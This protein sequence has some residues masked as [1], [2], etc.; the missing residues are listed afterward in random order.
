MSGW[1]VVTLSAPL[2]SFGEEAGNVQRGS[3]QRP[4]RSALIGLAGA[5]FG[6][7]REDDEGQRA[8][9]EAF[10]VASRTISPGR[11]LVDFH[12]YQS[13]PRGQAVATRAEALNRRADLNTSITRR[14][15]RADGLW[16][17]A[18]AQRPAAR[19]TL[20]G[21]MAAF[22]QPLFALWLGRKSC[23]LAH[24]LCPV[25]VPTDD[26][27]VAFAT[28]GARVSL[29]AGQTGGTLGVDETDAHRPNA[30]RRERRVDEPLNRR[31]WHFGSRYELVYDMPESATPLREAEA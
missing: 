15:Y 14:T 21:L 8:L 7:S 20:D 22:R 30:Y 25:L 10:A 2:A 1:L 5:A 23:P 13:L 16:Q 11:P 19:F 31:R 4:T 26:V 6:I 27:T 12:T 17:A 18:Y 9:A 28:Q 24:P 3:S 29:T